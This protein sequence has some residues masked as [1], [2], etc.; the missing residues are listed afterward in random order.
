MTNRR[1]L[2]L[3]EMVAALGSI[4]I[5]AGLG[6]TLIH[7]LLRVERSER[8]SLAQQNNLARLSREFRQ[9]VRGAHA[10]EPAG[11]GAETLASILLKSSDQ[12]TVEYRIKGESIVRTRRH[13]EKIV[14]T[15]TFKLPSVGTARLTVS[16]SSGQTV[17]S[18]LVD[19]K[20]GKRGEG[21][22]REFRVDAR[23]GRDRRF[24]GAGE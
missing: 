9:D 16:G 23:L 13:A 14:R 8:A 12:E 24:V 7:S 11:D 3:I 22:S 5:L 21:D 2:S 1:G 20:A 15:E 6:V 18:L 19:R 10:T 17:V 4:A